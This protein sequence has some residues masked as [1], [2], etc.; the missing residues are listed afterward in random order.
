MTRFVL[1]FIA[2]VFAGDAVAQARPLST[3]MSC[4]QASGLVNSGGGVVLSTG[5]FTYDR[6]VSSGRI[7][8][9]SEITEPAWVPT[10]DTQQCFVGYRC[11]SLAQRQSSR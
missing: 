8:G 4:A 7:C 9:T 10:S 6:Y 2:V 11:R 5:P 3:A 1:V